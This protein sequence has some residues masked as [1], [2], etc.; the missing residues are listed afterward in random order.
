MSSHSEALTREEVCS[1]IA[2]KVRTRRVPM[3]IHF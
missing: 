2:G 3:F 1:V